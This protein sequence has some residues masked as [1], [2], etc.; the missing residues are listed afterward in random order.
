MLRIAF[1]VAIGIYV[2]Q[3]YNVPNVKSYVKFIQ[4]SLVDFEKDLSKEKN[5]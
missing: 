5:R 3:N 2:A 1:G 4:Q